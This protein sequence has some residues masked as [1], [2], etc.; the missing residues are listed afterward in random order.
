MGSES[1][2]A[3]LSRGRV[4]FSLL[5]GEDEIS[6]VC[7]MHQHGGWSILEKFQGSS[8]DYYEGYVALNSPSR[9]EQN[10]F[11]EGFPWWLRR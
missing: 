10:S 6:R 7:A 11:G 4:N 5:K 3:E 9:L 2:F 1:M 8:K